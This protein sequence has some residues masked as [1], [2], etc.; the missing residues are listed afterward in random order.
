V[1]ICAAR[2]VGATSSEGLLVVCCVGV[3]QRQHWMSIR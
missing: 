3:G 2:V 1:K